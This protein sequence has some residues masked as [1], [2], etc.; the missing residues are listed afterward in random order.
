MGGFKRSEPQPAVEDD[1]TSDDIEAELAAYAR[2]AARKPPLKNM[3]VFEI[4]CLYSLVLFK[5]FIRF[6]N[7]SDWFF[8]THSMHI[9]GLYFTT[10]ILFSSS[11]V[12]M[13][14]NK[15][16]TQNLQILKNQRRKMLD[17]N[18]QLRRFSSPV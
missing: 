6:F 9:F 7:F 13:T 8:R 17:P 11:L 5:F 16:L 1:S 10:S 3:K 2:P 12:W 15:T 18:L 14:M 4:C